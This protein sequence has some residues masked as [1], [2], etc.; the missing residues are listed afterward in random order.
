MRNA[1]VGGMLEGRIM[2]VGRC[3]ALSLWV[4]GAMVVAS[5][6]IAGSPAGKAVCP[7]RD[8]GRL[9]FVDVFDGPP[10][11]LAS[12]KPDIGGGASGAFTVGGIYDAGRFVTLRCRYADG[13]IERVELRE[14][15]GSCDYRRGR[16]G[17]LSFA[18]R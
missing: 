7:A 5:P 17:G 1:V 13:T 16:D 10:E 15:V 3:W 18:C 4:M 8:G 11:E 9:K 12:L 6:A 2:A 14:R